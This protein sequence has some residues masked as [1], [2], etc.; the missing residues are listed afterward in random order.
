MDSLDLQVVQR[1][2]GWIAAGKSIWLCTVVS[3]FG[4]AP[5]GPGAMLVRTLPHKPQPSYVS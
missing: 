5:R 3:T 2:Q 1:A 4:S